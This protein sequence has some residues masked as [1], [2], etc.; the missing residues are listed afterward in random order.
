MSE[1]EKVACPFCNTEVEL[2]YQG[3]ITIGPGGPLGCTPVSEGKCSECGVHVSVEASLGSP[4]ILVRAY[5]SIPKSIGAN[6][7]VLQQ[8]EVESYTIREGVRV[9]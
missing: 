5:M 3:G 9:P 4:D 6:V 7:V 8:D 1:S 2:E